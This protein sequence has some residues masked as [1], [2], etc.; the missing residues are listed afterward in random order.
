MSLSKTQSDREIVWAK[1]NRVLSIAMVAANSMNYEER[2]TI[3]TGYYVTLLEEIGSSIKEAIE[4]IDSKSG[5][6]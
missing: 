3:E 2:A 5:S 6:L 4:I 1:L